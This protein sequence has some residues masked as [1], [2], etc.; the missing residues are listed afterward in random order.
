MLL[1]KFQ[2]RAIDKQTAFPKVVINRMWK[3]PPTSGAFTVH[4]YKFNDY[5]HYFLTLTRY[6]NNNWDSSGVFDPDGFVA[7][8]DCFSDILTVERI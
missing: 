7:V 1:N 2:Q 6:T 5:A 3:L 8:D 4:Q